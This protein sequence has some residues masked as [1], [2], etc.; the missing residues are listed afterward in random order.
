MTTDSTLLAHLAL[1]LGTH[2]ENIAVEA[3]GHI[4]SSSKASLRAVED[5]LKA[6]GA[7]IGTISHARTQASK[8]KRGRPDL[9]GCD[10]NGEERVLIEAKFW[11]GLTE[12]Q[13]VTYLKRLPPD[14]PAALLF[15][16][17]LARFETLWDALLGRVR[18]SNMCLGPDEKKDEN[19]R[20]TQVEGKHCLMLTSWR[21]LL[22]RMTVRASRDRD[23]C[24]EANIRQL[25]G[26][27]ERMDK[28]AFLPLRSAEFGPEFPRRVL[29]LQRLT[30][31]VVER[32]R[33][34][35]WVDRSGLRGNPPWSWYMR[36]SGAGT[37]FGIALD[38]WAQAQYRD[39]PLW[40]ILETWGGDN[41]LTANFEVVRRKILSLPQKNQ[42]G[43][44][45]KGEKIYIP[46]D[47]PVG[48][49]YDTVLD[50]VVKRLEDIARLIDSPDTTS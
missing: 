24:V 25:L 28:D 7:E 26:L 45:D 49:E 18:K 13:P 44:I 1:K 6:G 50:A 37:W 38:L 41:T 35:D 31:D 40:V 11:A 42:L 47:L 17:P 32:V 36:L 14:K 39:T 29:G 23:S 43:V 21:S 34:K 16:A 9:S 2:P 22:E 46:I 4:L 8:E 12:H 48:V 3:L 33:G 10:E 20:V 15:V 30:K 5:L 27:T 19:L